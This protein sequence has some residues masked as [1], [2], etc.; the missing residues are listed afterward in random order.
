MTLRDTIGSA[1][2]SVLGVLLIVAAVF[3]PLAHVFGLHKVELP[4]AVIFAFLIGGM[5]L[6]FGSRVMAVLDKFSHAK[7]K[8]FGGEIDFDGDDKDT[9]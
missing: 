1:V 4:T 9:E 6:A 7:I 3:S 8:A 5:V 2:A